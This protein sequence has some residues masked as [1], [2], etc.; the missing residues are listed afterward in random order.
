MKKLSFN[1]FIF[2]SKK[3]HGSKYDYSLVNYINNKT[4]VKIICPIHGIFEQSPLH[5]MNGVSCA[6][7]KN[8]KRK[9][10]EQFIKEARKI[11]NNKYNYSKTVYINANT[12]VEIICP[13]HGSFKQIARLHLISSGCIFCAVHSLSNKEDFIK[14]AK[15]IH[16]NKY[17]YSKVNYNKSNIKIEIICPVHGKFFQNPNNHLSGQG[18]P[19]CNIS[20]GENKIKR[21]LDNYN[22][23]Y[24]REYIFEKLPRKKFD[25]YLEKQNTCIEYDGEHHF[26][27]IKYWGG[28]EKLD[29][30]KNNDKIKNEFCKENGINLIRIPYTEFN[31]I[32]SILDRKRIMW[33]N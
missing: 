20:K 12:K 3:V 21:I 30:T 2:R 10:T 33:Y 4:K 13:I 29:Y 9:S 27:E 31:D 11:H 8:V 23:S 5:H 24:I 19:K 15:I 32:D 1:E 26:K 28:K 7:C 25:F 17:N 22:I 6:A 16:E 18:C 14:K